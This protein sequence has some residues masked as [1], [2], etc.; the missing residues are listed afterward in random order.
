MRR[1]PADV[2]PTNKFRETWGGAKPL[3]RPTTSPSAGPRSTPSAAPAN[4]W[5]FRDLTDEGLAPWA[6]VRE[7]SAGGSPDA[8]HGVDV[9]PTFERG[10]A[11]LQAHD[12]YLRGL[13]SGTFDP[14]E[15]LES[16][17][18]PVGAR[19]GV[20]Y[21]ASFEVF[22]LQSW[23]PARISDVGVRYPVASR[24]Q[25]PPSLNTVPGRSGHIS[26]TT[27]PTV[28]ASGRPAT[29]PRSPEASRCMEIC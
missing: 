17:S 27:F 9:T 26:S 6:G 4:R 18:R 15:F 14:Q 3:N 10:V 2:V 7:V 23:R 24:S 28:P 19:I 11:S 12:A 29:H 13:G 20:T 1:H 25:R 21:G 22:R 16:F 5:V 8:R